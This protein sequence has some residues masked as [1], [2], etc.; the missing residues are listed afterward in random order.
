MASDV[1]LADTGTTV[2]DRD[3]DVYKTLDG[4]PLHHLASYDDHP[5]PLGAINESLKEKGSDHRGPMCLY[6]T[7]IVTTPRVNDCHCHL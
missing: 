5:G 2:S 1:S 4:M 7:S 3:F 6:I